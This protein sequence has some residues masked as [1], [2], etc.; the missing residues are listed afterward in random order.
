[1][2]RNT[3]GLSPA[4]RRA[5]RALKALGPVF[6]GTVYL[7]LLAPIIIVI[8][9]S[10]NS[11]LYLSFPPKGFSLRW[12]GRYF[13]DPIYIDSSLK[14]LLVG[15]GAVLL[16]TVFGTMAA[17]AL[18]R[19]RPPMYGLINAMILS[20]LLLP[21]V[22]MGLA[23]LYTLSTLGL[24]RSMIS[25]VLGHTL[26]VLPFVVI[27]VSSALQG[28]ERHLEEVAMS[29]G[30]SQWYAF[31]TVTLPIIFPGIVSGALFA[32]ILSLDEFIITFLLGGVHVITLP[33]RIFTSLRFAVDPTIAAV[34][35]VFVFVTTILFV[36]ATRLKARE[37][38]TKIPSTGKGGF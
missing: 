16:S 28:C 36:V 14:S 31:R 10:F 20:P 37:R 1:M 2:E 5:A 12:Y 32:F 4:N 13:S 15:A 8:V 38:Q 22:V 6:A 30:A 11:A 34:S 35:T 29:L 21:G 27:I 19:Y 3:T 25:V 26:Y 18:Q 33:I 7:F 23:L 17:Y 24:G 9:M